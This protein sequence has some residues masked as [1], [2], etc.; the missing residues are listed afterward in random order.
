MVQ[1]HSTK[2]S[3]EG[4]AHREGAS[5][6]REHLPM[7]VGRHLDITLQRIINLD[8]AGSRTVYEKDCRSYRFCN[9]DLIVSKKVTCPLEAATGSIEGKFHHADSE[10]PGGILAECQLPPFMT[11]QM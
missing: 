3:E 2:P 5:R 9:M 1:E 6:L 7:G 10:P 4:G 8:A 11:S